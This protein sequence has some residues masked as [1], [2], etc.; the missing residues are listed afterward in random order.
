MKL[1]VYF[2]RQ[3]GTNLFFK[4]CK[5]WGPLWVAINSASAW[6]TKQGVASAKG[7]ITTKRQRMQLDYE[8]DIIEGEVEVHLKE[9]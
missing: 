8:C 7:S 5:G 1:K 4:R 9:N 2:L 6:T 3:R